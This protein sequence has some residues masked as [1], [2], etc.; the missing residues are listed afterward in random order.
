MADGGD[1]TRGRGRG[2]GRGF[3]ADFDKAREEAKSARSATAGG[4]HQ[5]GKGSRAP[6]VAF[7][8]EEFGFGYQ[9]LRGYGDVVRGR[10]GLVPSGG[11]RPVNQRNVS[12]PID[13]SEPQRQPLRT[14]EQSLTALTNGD[15][16]FALVPLYDPELGYDT[17]SLKLLSSLFGPLGIDQIEAGDHFC[18]AVYESQVLE[19]AQASHPGSSLANL[20]GKMRG[21]YAARLDPGVDWTG[22][23]PTER[24][25]DHA[26]PSA[27]A[28]LQ[29]SADDQLVL[30]DRIEMV[31]AGPEALR[32]CRA[33][34][35]GLA[36]AG[37][38]IQK[39]AQW[40][41]PHREMARRVRESFDHSRQVQTFIDPNGKPQLLSSMSA[42]AQRQPLFGVILPFEVAMRSPEFMIVDPSVEDSSSPTTRYLVC[43]KNYDDSL[44]EDRYKL[45]SLRVDYWM[46]RINAVK[47]FDQKNRSA[48]RISEFFRL[49]SSLW[50]TRGGGSG[51]DNHAGHDTPDYRGLKERPAVRVLMQF[52]R[53]IGAVTSIGTVEDYL[54]Y[55]GVRYSTVR[56]SEDSEAS[57]ANKPS[58]LVLDIEFDMRD[59]APHPKIGSVVEGFLWK[60]FNLRRFGMPRFLAVMPMYEHQLPELD[61]RRWWNEGV[62][63]YLHSLGQK[64]EAVA[65]YFIGH[66]VWEP[67]LKL[68]ALPVKAVLFTTFVIG[69]FL[70]PQPKSLFFRV[71]SLA[72][73]GAIAWLFREP[74]FGVMR[75]LF[76]GLFA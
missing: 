75:A 67:L 61:Q 54:R 19:L 57:G 2:R 41:E 44:F 10:G 72:L 40:I 32:R 17:E 42:Q 76:P 7:N 39:T 13:F 11:G 23:M 12:A 53:G 48:G 3:D 20:L 47:N 15:A 55:Y 5:G 36:A 43:E 65:G 58:P 30:R 34:L 68:F 22:G 29:L 14:K 33:K 8:G 52:E 51:H 73:V 37:V 24:R 26:P 63:A 25:R 62:D 59:F 27:K 50:T 1:F 21:Q 16:D 6:R 9:A 46:K 28:G 49:M 45:N 66:Y 71:T 38:T 74:I 4:G 18:L 64:G 70:D 69:E 35:D 60:A 56:L 31:F